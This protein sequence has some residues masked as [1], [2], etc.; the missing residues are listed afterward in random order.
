MAANNCNAHFSLNQ[1]QAAAF[2]V[3]LNADGTMQ[4]LKAGEF[5]IGY[6]DEIASRLILLASSI[7]NAARSALY[8]N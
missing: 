4:Y 6:A 3:V 7:R 2:G 5:D 1:D 8:Q